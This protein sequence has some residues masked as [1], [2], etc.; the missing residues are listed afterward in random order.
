[1]YVRPIDKMH[2]EITNRC[3]AAC[4]SCPRTGDFKGKLSGHMTMAGW[5][6]ISLDDIKE[7]HKNV[8]EHSKYG[9]FGR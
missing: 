9:I 6:D 7:I 1:M 4:P 8:I 5:H 3:N 2:L